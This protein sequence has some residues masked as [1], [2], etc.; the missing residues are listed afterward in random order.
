MF[1]NAQIVAQA[2]KLSQAAQYISKTLRTVRLTP[3]TPED[4]IVICSIRDEIA[5]LPHFLRHYRS[6]GVRKFVFIDNGSI[7]GSVAHLLQQDDCDVYECLEDY[8]D[9]RSGIIWKNVILARYGAAKWFF[10]ADADELAVYDG[11]PGLS[12]DELASNLGRSGFA[13][14]PGLMVDMYCG[15]PLKDAPHARSVSDLVAAFPYF[16]GDGYSITRPSDWRSESFPRQVVNGGPTKRLYD[17]QGY[18]WL[19]KTPLLLEPGI[20]YLDPHTVLP[21][22]LNFNP[23][24]IALLHFRFTGAL[25]DKIKLVEQ[26]GYAR[27]NVERYKSFGTCMAEDPDFTFHYPGSVKFESPRQFVERMMIEPI[28]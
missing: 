7:D 15:G 20:R 28:I 8:K 13:S 4:G 16:D 2:T 5:H 17:Q 14:V 9:S 12:L 22:G 18:G 26:R 27:K 25:A 1:N 6:I 10:S 19:A 24:R 11:W 23:I 3:A 21:V